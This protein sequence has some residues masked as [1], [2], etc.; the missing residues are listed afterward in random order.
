MSELEFTMSLKELKENNPEGYE[1]IVQTLHHLREKQLE[2]ES[3]K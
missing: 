2:K 1:L 3:V